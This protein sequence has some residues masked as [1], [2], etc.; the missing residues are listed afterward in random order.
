MILYY[1]VLYN[2]F[3]NGIYVI[4]DFICIVTSI[5]NNKLC[6]I[7]KNTNYKT[8]FAWIICHSYF[9]L[10]NWFISSYNYVY[11]AKINIHK[12]I[13]VL[14]EGNIRL[15][16]TLLLFDITITIT[17]LLIVTI[18]PY[19]WWSA[20]KSILILFTI[21]LNLFVIITVMYVSSSIFFIIYLYV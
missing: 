5:D 13:I 16:S 7:W 19:F 8:Y 11:K 4:V 10:N 21:N 12:I 20:S 18:L 2:F 1:I 17:L 14:E 15:A 6:N 9:Y 3:M